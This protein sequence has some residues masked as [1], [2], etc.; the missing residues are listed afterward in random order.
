MP[1]LTRILLADDHA[2][3]RRGLRDLLHSEPDLRVVAEAGDGAE[4]IRQA[5]SQDVDLVILD[6]TMPRITGL[7]A[8]RALT[9]RG[10]GA[11]ILVLSMHEGEQFVFEALRAGA[12][13]FVVKT[14][15]DRELIDACRAVMRGETFLQAGAVGALER[16]Q[17]VRGPEDPLTPREV[18][19]LK[20]VA[21]GRTSEEIAQFLV[22]SI[23]TV[24]RHRGRILEKLGLRD[25][26]DMTRYAIRRGLIEP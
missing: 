8:A 26:I 7:Q 11:K 9:A 15:A 5:E 17:L 10:H 4:A 18:E 14:S 12:S 3:V 1:G 25:R 24:D 16:A 13:G 20:L 6:V 23:N 21:E 22:I 2:I 19:V